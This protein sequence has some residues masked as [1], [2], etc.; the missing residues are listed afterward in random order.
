MT[1]SVS[2]AP[3]RKKPIRRAQV[4]LHMVF[5]IICASYILPLALTVAI[6]F[7]TQVDIINYGYSLIPLSVYFRG[8]LVKLE[9]GLCKGKKLYDKREDAAKKD[10][11]RQI[12]RAMKQH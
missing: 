9:I 10:A 4:I 11:K 1:Q 5:I 3:R 6:S 8:P 12:D 2:A 7:S